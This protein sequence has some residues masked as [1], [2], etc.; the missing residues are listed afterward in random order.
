M[1]KNQA[2]QQ[3]VAGGGHELSSGPNAREGILDMSNKDK[4]L[5]NVLRGVLVALQRRAQS[6]N[7]AYLI[8]CV[9]FVIAAVYALPKGVGRETAG[10]LARRAVHDLTGTHDKRVGTRKGGNANPVLGMRKTHEHAP[11]VLSERVVSWIQNWASAMLKATP[12]GDAIVAM[13]YGLAKLPDPVI[14]DFKTI[15]SQ[16]NIELWQYSDDLPTLLETFVMLAVTGWVMLTL[17]ERGQGP[18]RG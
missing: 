7:P 8:F 5:E 15:E 10:V 18:K 16:V 17:T 14:A 3:R 11:R 2:N 1:K 4:G 9:R 12:F 6:L 13:Q